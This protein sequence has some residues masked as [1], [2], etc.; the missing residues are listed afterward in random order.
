MESLKILSRWEGNSESISKSQAVQ[1]IRS[2]LKMIRMKNRKTM[3]KMSSVEAPEVME[4]E[5]LDF[6]IALPI[7]GKI[8]RLESKEKEGT[9]AS[10]QRHIARL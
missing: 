10:F 7:R 5:Y 9:P 6:S 2:V 8:L 3:M 4:E 1:G